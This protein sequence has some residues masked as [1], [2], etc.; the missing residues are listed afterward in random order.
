MHVEEGEDHGKL[1]GDREEHSKDW[2]NPHHGVIHLGGS[3]YQLD[4]VL[5]MWGWVELLVATLVT[6]ACVLF[7]DFCSDTQARPAHFQQELEE[8]EHVCHEE[9]YLFCLV[10]R[11][12]FCHVVMLLCVLL[13]HLLDQ[14]LD[15]QYGYHQLQDDVPENEVSVEEEL[16]LTL[17]LRVLG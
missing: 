17:D 8:V 2:E 11:V 3:Y 12:L 7:L 5:V 1:L 14:E 16:E 4:C 10:E 6:V 9:M 15:P 13:L